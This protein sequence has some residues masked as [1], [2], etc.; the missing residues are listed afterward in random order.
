MV[1]IIFI[2]TGYISFS[3]NIGCIY[4]EQMQYFLDVWGCDAFA[5]NFF[6]NLEIAKVKILQIHL[7]DEIV[8]TRIS[9]PVRLTRNW[10]CL[11]MFFCFYLV[12]A[13]HAVLL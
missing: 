2:I 7:M 9:Y 13:F 8:F 6:I 4:A 3:N 12:F 11:L 5:C 10:S 1:F